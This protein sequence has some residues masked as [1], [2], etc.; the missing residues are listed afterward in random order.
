MDINYILTL[1]AFLNLAGDLYNIFRFRNQLPHWILKL[2]LG[3]LAICVVA[4]FSF[5]DEC[6]YIALPTLICYH[7]ILRLRTRPIRRLPSS[8]GTPATIAII[9]LTALS[10]GNQLYNDAV[11]NPITLIQV[12]ALYSPFVEAG[13]WWRLFSAQFIH[14]GIAHLALNML[15]LWFLGRSVERTLGT[16]RYVA[17]YLLCGAGGMTIAWLTNYIT[18]PG[19]PIIL[20][21]ASASVLGMV[22][23]QAALSLIAYRRTGSMIAKAQLAAMT[24]IIALQ[25]IFD[26]SVPQVSSTA[27]IGGAASGFLIGLVIANRRKPQIIT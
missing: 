17:A 27:H 19:N 23:L 8:T 18:N 4:F 13:E 10:F 26:L 14:W 3:A 6:G 25:T 22:G 24:Q 9:A 16:S 7:I 5:P 15:G 21:G 12:G 2:N 20:L 11:D 1:I